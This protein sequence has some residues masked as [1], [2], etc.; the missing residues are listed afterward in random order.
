MRNGIINGTILPMDAI[1]AV[2]VRVPHTNCALHLASAGKAN[3]AIRHLTAVTKSILPH[4]P[5]VASSM[6]AELHSWHST[7]DFGSRDVIIAERIVGPVNSFVQ[8]P[9][10]SVA[11][12]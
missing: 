6:L 4:T 2:A 8:V 11:P 5:P 3:N 1:Q 10:M 12:P 7:G 9:L